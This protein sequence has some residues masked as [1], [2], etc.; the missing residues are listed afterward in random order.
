[1]VILDKD[2]KF[3]RSEFEKF[4]FVW[5]DLMKA[6]LGNRFTIIVSTYGSDVVPLPSPDGSQNGIWYFPRT[7]VT[8]I[9]S[10]LIRADV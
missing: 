6:M 7:V 8:K 3:V 2:E 10:K 4:N 9:C 5:D 1:M